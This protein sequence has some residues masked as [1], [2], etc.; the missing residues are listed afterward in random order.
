MPDER[1]S[2]ERTRDELRAG[3][4]AAFFGSLA[5][6]LAVAGEAGLTPGELQV[7]GTVIPMVESDVAGARTDA[8]AHWLSASCDG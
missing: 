4:P 3:R 5:Q 6:L 1:P 2:R 8:D 7:H